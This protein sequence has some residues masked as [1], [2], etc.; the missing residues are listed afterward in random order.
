MSLFYHL[1]FISRPGNITRKQ[2][3]SKARKTKGNDEKSPEKSPKL[4]S[5]L[6]WKDEKNEIEVSPYTDQS[7]P[8]FSPYQHYDYINFEPI[9]VS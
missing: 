2:G 7:D 1:H 3:L 6:S 9:P 4:A 8:N 5:K